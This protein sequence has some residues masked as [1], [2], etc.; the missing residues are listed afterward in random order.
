M[1]SGMGRGISN[2]SIDKRVGSITC[3][4]IGIVDSNI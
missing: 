4:R 1:G 3:I 2:V